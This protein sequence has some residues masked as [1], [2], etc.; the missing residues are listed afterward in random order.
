[1]SYNGSNVLF[2]IFVEGHIVTISAK[3]FSI[4]NT[5]FREGYLSIGT[6]WK[7][8]NPPGGNVFKDQIR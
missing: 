4:P 8:V 3:L 6:K 2:A 7:L 5:G 1:M